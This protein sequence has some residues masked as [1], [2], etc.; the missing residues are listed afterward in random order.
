MPSR[1]DSLGRMRE[2]TP[3]CGA[4]V[5]RGSAWAFI[6]VL[7]RRL[8]SPILLSEHPR[9]WRVYRV[10]LPPRAAG[11]ATPTAHLPARHA[12]GRRSWHLS[13]LVGLGGC[14]GVEGPFPSAGLDEWAKV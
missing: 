12:A 11:E 9:I 13:E 14:P 1:S 7:H 2:T 4:A 5:A 3:D 8:G 6:A 10:H